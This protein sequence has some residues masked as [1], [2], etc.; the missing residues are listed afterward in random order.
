MIAWM[1]TAYQLEG[2]YEARQAR[3]QHPPTHSLTRLPTATGLTPL[4][5]P[6]LPPL[7]LPPHMPRHAMPHTWSSP[8]PAIFSRARAAASCRRRCKSCCRW[9]QSWRW[10]GGTSGGRWVPCGTSSTN[11]MLRLE[12]RLLQLNSLLPPTHLYLLP[13]LLYPP[14][15]TLPPLTLSAPKSGGATSLSRSSWSAPH[16]RRQDAHASR[17]STRECT[18][19]SGSRRHAGIRVVDNSQGS[20]QQYASDTPHMLSPQGLFN[21]RPPHPHT[22]T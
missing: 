5:P 1:R 17:R 20:C 11:K 19:E 9:C 7:P 21:A 14:S 16:R 2:G 8:A 4:G 22:L 6:P 12:S 13:S 18:R 3:R 10:G 15:H